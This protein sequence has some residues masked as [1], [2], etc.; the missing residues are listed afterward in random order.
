MGEDPYK[1]N[2]SF[3][4]LIQIMN[5][6]NIELCEET[7]HVLTYPANNIRVTI[8]AHGLNPENFDINVNYKDDSFF[9]LKYLLIN[10]L[11]LRDLR[12]GWSL[13]KELNTYLS[14]TLSLVKILPMSSRSQDV[15][16]L[17]TGTA[18]STMRN[19]IM[20]P[21]KSDLMTTVLQKT[22][23]PRE[24]APTIEMDRDSL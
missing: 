21:L 20:S 2:L 17:N 9:K 22:S 5:W 12:I 1:I 6:V 4:Q 8:L 24:H 3:E 15:K 14:D 11:T 19:L 18:L 13:I 23:L 7:K 10:N 16:W